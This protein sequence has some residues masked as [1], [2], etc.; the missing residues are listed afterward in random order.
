MSRA[1]ALLAAVPINQVLSA[2]PR[3]AFFDEAR[4]GFA[5]RRKVGLT[6]EA[7]YEVEKGAPHGA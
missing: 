4:P 6:L 1:I 5:D 7:R 3:T 2:E